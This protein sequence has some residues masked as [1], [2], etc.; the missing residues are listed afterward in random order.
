LI[1]FCSFLCLTLTLF[2]LNIRG[3]IFIS[4]SFT[5]SSYDRAFNLSLTWFFSVFWE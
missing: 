3:Q 1:L 4:I 5:H 2:S